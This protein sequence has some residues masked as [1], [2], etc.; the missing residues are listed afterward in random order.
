MSESKNGILIHIFSG[1]HMGAEILVPQG[2]YLFG[3][4]DSCDYILMDKNIAPH[5][6]SLEILA[7]PLTLGSE[8]RQDY[9]VRITPLEGRLSINDTEIAEESEWEAETLLSVQGTLIV[10]A[11]DNMEETVQNCRKHF[12][13]PAAPKSAEQKD[14]AEPPAEETETLPEPANNIDSTEVSA[15]KTQKKF[16]PK[17]NYLGIVLSAVAL[18]ALIVTFTPIGQSELKDTQAIKKLLEENGFPDIEVILTDK[19]IMWQG[20]LGNDRE[21]AQ[22][23]SLAQKMQFPVY[24]DITVREDIVKTLKNIYSLKKIMPTVTV[25]GKK[26][27]VGYYVKDELYKEIAQKNLAVMLPYYK[28]IEDRLSVSTVY[29]KELAERI[30]EKLKKT[31]VKKIN[32]VFEEGRVY[33]GSSHSRE[34]EKQIRTVMDEIS[35]ELGFQI[36]YRFAPAAI[37]EKSEKTAVPAKTQGTA[38]KRQNSGFKVISVNTGAIP[39]ITLSS[40]EKIFI[41]GVL[42]DGGILESV[43]LKELTINHN[44]SVT[45]YPL[46]GNQ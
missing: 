7:K 9:S 34:E 40:N 18:A 14:T 22:L 36:P 29:E 27:F 21:R 5:H 15:E 31:A 38:E 30:K 41:G 39:F 11:K 1:C 44:G 43:S 20:I 2:K 19:G 6:F 12:Y 10:W 46:R 26:I 4:D 3:N 8:D 25:D 37:A 42:P 32:P 24:L 33:F 23:H 28:E 16:S 35:G 17:K 13:Q 45:I